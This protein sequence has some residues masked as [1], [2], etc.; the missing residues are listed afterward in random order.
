MVPSDQN[1]KALNQYYVNGLL[2]GP[3]F[4]Q[5]AFK[6]CHLFLFFFPLSE[7]GQYCPAA[8]LSTPARLQ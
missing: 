6:V 8:L 7:N 5:A 1:I 2:Q 4:R 3:I